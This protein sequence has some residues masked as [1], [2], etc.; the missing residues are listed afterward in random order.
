M[1][2]GSFQGVPSNNLVRGPEKRMAPKAHT[3]KTVAAPPT[4]TAARTAR[5]P[6][7]SLLMEHL[8]PLFPVPILPGSEGGASVVGFSRR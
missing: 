2:A 4:S 7:R 5:S 8:R 1:M 3:A 6:A